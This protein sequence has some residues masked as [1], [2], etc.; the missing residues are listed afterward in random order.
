VRRLQIV[1]DIP[2][3]TADRDPLPLA[4]DMLTAYDEYSVS[5]E[6]VEA[7]WLNEKADQ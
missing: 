6:I 1:I 3:W 2:D 7:R 5:G 4:R